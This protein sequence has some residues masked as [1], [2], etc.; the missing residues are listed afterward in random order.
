MEVIL[1]EDVEAI[2]SIGDIVKVKDGYARNFLVPRKLAIPKTK[3]N[4]KIVEEQKR[5]ATV[6]KEKEKTKFS[7][8][9]EKISAMSC[10]ITVQAG[11]EDK[12]FGAVTNAD[13][14]KALAAEGVELDKRKILLV[15]P[16]KQLGIYTVD[17]ELH[18]EVTSSLKVWIVKE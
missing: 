12:L 5:L 7:Q 2:G 11:E 15:E 10:T 17:I 16:I 6:R 13:I 3:A 1:L 18:P 8:L 9:A 4:A 14:Q